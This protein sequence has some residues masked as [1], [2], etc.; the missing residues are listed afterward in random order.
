VTITFGD[1]AGGTR[2]TI[3]T[4][5]QT[6]ADREAAIAGGF[7][8]GWNDSLDRLATLLTRAQ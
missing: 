1:A 6:A 5:L 2:I 3:H 7:N 8:S 4:Q